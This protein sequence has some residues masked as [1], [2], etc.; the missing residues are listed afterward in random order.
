MVFDGGYGAWAMRLEQA[1]VALLPDA[2]WLQAD[3]GGPLDAVRRMV[4]SGIWGGPF[5]DELH[6]AVCWLDGQLVAWGEHLGRLLTA[7]DQAAREAEAAARLEVAGVVPSF[8]LPGA[9]AP[10]QRWPAASPPLPVDWAG[11]GAWR[12]AVVWVEPDGAR[13]LAEGIRSVAEQLRGAERRVISALSDVRIEAPP[14]LKAVSDGLDEVAGEIVHRV[15]LLENVDRELA[16]AFRDLANRLGFTGRLAPPPTFDPADPIDSARAGLACPVTAGPGNQPAQLKEADPVSVSTGNYL[17]QTLDVVISGGPGGGVRFGRT[18]NSLAAGRVGAFGFGWSHTFDVRLTPGADGATLRHGDGREEQLL[19]G[20]AR[21]RT[22][23]GAAEFTT[24]AR[25]VWRFDA[26]GSLAMATDRSS[27]RWLLRYDDVGHLASV[28]DPSGR[29]LRF[30]ADDGRRIVAVTDVLG[31][32]WRYDYDEAGDLV[33]AV[34]PAGARW[35]YAYDSAHHLVSLTDPDGGLVVENTYDD[36]GRVIAQVDSA[37]AR[38][39]YRYQ[40]VRTVVTDPLGRKRTYGV[41]ERFRTS[42]VTDAAGDSTRFAWDES[43][44]LVATTDATGRSWRAVYDDK[45]DVTRLS[46]PDGSAVVYRYDDQRNLVAVVGADGSQ[47]TLEYDAASRPVRLV[48]PGGATTALT[49]RS[50]GLVSAVTNGV[51][52]TSRFEYDD[53]GRLSALVD[54]LGAVTRVTTDAAGQVTREMHPDGAAIH[55][56]WDPCGRL[57]GVTDPQGA[58][59]RY[60]YDRAG[61]LT[62][63]TDALGRATRYGWDPRGLLTSVTD[64]LGRDSTFTYDLARRLVTRIDARGVPVTFTWDALDRLT[65]I[66]PADGPASRFTY[67]RAG[68]LASMS[69]AT[70]TT[71]LTYDGADRPIREARDLGA[72]ALVHN[73]DPMGR[74]RGLRLERDGEA[75]ATW[76]YD[77]DADGRV[78]AVTDP[79]GGRT[80]LTCDAAG[81]LVQ[82]SHPNGVTS[83]F[84]HDAAAQ[85]VELTH[86]NAAGERFGQLACSY[87]P[88]GN[89]T[90]AGAVRFRYDALGRLSGLTVPGEAE[91]AFAYDPVGNRTAAGTR[92]FSYDDL[93]QIVSD[94]TYVYEHDAAGNLVARRPLNGGPGELTCTWDALGRLLALTADGHTTTF[95]YDALGR[96]VLR[97][98]AS[99]V[100]TRVFDS[101]NVVEEHRDDQPGAYE[102]TAGLLVLSRID[103]DGRVEYLHPDG[104]ANVAWTTGPAGIPR[105]APELGPWGEPLG[106]PLAPGTP[107]FAGTVGVRAEAAGL[108]DMRA[109]L[110]DPHLGRFISRDPWPATLPGPATLNRYAYALNDPVSLLDPFGLFCW[111]GKNAEGKC[112]GLKDVA[113]RLEKPLEVVST[114]ATAAAV[115]AIGITVV[116]PPCGLVTLPVATLSEIATAT[117]YVAL[118]TGLAVTGMN[119]LEKVVSFDCA[120][121]AVTMAVGL[122]VGGQIESGMGRLAS[123]H[124]MAAAP[125]ATAKFAAGMFDLFSEGSSAAIDRVRK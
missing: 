40:V 102:T 61:R 93:D 12:G 4:A 37:G 98:N 123:S 108:W 19:P 116:C 94:G 90:A 20:D 80:A 22:V 59:W 112:R 55:F 121:G 114:V 91:T 17:H 105:P 78:G 84:T 44:R 57:V 52:A 26:T 77:Y 66:E 120:K 76:T 15:T 75:I 88:S 6:G 34:D 2:R 79:A 83:K 30:E 32:A 35:T 7:L 89:R 92:A 41:D 33:A 54:A 49:W 60:T 96:R 72:V 45:G 115:I 68:R 67:D 69:D 71:V 109:R 118:G 107:G 65:A 18:Y 43:S 46:G 10:W 1:C 11:R 124:I 25:A 106:P 103:P 50:D 23:D 81:N 111:T 27:N 74:R 24:S 119:C 48:S 29:E 117:R 82:V 97:R 16:G 14:F 73:Y 13:R 62:S 113:H 110:Y 85:L 5:A 58:S 99:G 28:E 51:G 53:V 3:V 39:S 100:T 36:S 125:E 86:L 87:D 70:G 42:F 21:V 122:G 9:L 38:W 56:E 63:L 47:V 8:D 95:G 64:P 104:N 101:A 31:R